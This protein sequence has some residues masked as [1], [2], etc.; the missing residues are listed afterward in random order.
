MP[1]VREG[2]GD[3]H[4][5]ETMDCLSPSL[6]GFVRLG[7]GSG[8]ADSFWKGTCKGPLRQGRFTVA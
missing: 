1:M 4:R 6:L 7:L 3:K 2:P 5:I 8:Q